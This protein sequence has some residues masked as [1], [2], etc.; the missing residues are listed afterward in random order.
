MDPKTAKRL[1]IHLSKLAEPVK[2][3]NVDRTQNIAGLVES[4][5]QLDVTLGGRT[6]NLCFYIIE[7][8]NDRTILGFSFLKTFN[9][10][11]DWQTGRIDGQWGVTINQKDKV[12]N[13][14]QRLQIKAI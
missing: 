5:A 4:Y 2:I 10:K 11:I 7:L 6:K 1:K 8:G 14:L 12:T 13:R 3:L 9:P